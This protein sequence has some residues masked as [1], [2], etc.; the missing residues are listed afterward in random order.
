MPTIASY[1]NQAMPL[2]K[3]MTQEEVWINVMHLSDMPYTITGVETA[4]RNQRDK[5]LIE[6][7]KQSVKSRA[8]VKRIDIIGECIS[9][10]EL[11]KNLV[12]HK[13]DL[14][15]PKPGTLSQEVYMSQRVYL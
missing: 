10:E 3:V 8:Q 15:M 6:W 14:L 9:S 2:N 7:I 1:L 11:L 4:L 5:G 13:P 12:I